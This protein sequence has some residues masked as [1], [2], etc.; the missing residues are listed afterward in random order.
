MFGNSVINLPSHLL[1]EGVT[2]AAVVALMEFIYTGACIVTAQFASEVQQVQSLLQFQVEIE[3][4]VLAPA[5]QFPQITPASMEGTMLENAKLQTGTK[6]Q[7]GE[8]LASKPQKKPRIRKDGTKVRGK[9]SL[10]IKKEKTESGEDAT[11]LENEYEE[12]SEKSRRLEEVVKTIE[13]RSDGVSPQIAD[14]VRMVLPEE[15]SKEYKAQY[16]KVGFL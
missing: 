4:F 7:M 8:N 2:A 9:S 12:K 1:L 13:N 16:K 11:E 14:E 6:R 15:G 5:D 10:K 3:S